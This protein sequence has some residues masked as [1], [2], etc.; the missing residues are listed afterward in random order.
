MMVVNFYDTSAL[1]ILDELYAGLTLVSPIVLSELEHIK[2]S[3]DKDEKQK[4]QA[5]RATKLL[6]KNGFQ[7]ANISKKEI[8]K[9][10]KKYSFLSNN[11]DHSILA[12]AVAEKNRFFKGDT[13]NFFTADL[14][15]SYFGNQM[16]ELEIKFLE[17]K[18]TNTEY[19]GWKEYYLS[20]DAF[21]SIYSNPT[22]NILGAFTNEYCVLKENEEVKDI[23]KWDGE[24]YR[25]LEY[26]PVTSAVGQKW[27]PLNIEQKMLFD[28][29]QDD[30]V[31]VKL[32]LGNFGSGKSSL[33][34]THALEAI[35]KGKFEKI[36]FIRN[37]VEVKDTIPL[38]ALPNGETEKL[39][40]FLMPI[41]D[42]VGQ[43]TF[44]EMLNT[45]TIEACHL[46]FARGRDF[47]N[48]ILFCDECENLTVHQVQLLIGR[49][50]KGSALFF[51][52]DLRQ[53]DKLSFERN[54]GIKKM[55]ECLQNNKLFGMVKLQ[56]SVR[57][58]VCKLA[59]LMD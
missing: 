26:K 20:D 18:Q 40:P 22:E 33:M 28:L 4:F 46:G 39:L 15:L 3:R 21:S 35:Q 36:V 50:G 25:R 30:K 45:G 10:Y 17:E 48:C 14:L 6:R 44:E 11:N 51:A 41:C 2:S 8:K 55:I 56:Q 1:M 57:S 38:G 47:K 29:L 5:R 24:K 19:F 42:H 32:A 43:F 49:I 37:N 53:C 13:F 34:L 54:S 58:E 27:K 7:C 31:P 23:V 59:D 12:E 16:P 9:I 52:G